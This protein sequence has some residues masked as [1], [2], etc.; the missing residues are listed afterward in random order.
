MAVLLVLS[1][2][3]CF[4]IL[5]V[6]FFN[7]FSKAPQVASSG[8]VPCTLSATPVTIEKITADVLNG[9]GTS[10]LAK[11]VADQLAER[12]VTIRNIGN[13]SSGSYEG[14]IKITAG[15]TGIN[16]AYT[17]SRAF[18]DS[19]IIFDARTGSE[20]T[21]IVGKSYTGLIGASQFAEQATQPLTNRDNCK[22]VSTD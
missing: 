20:V 3:V 16:S 1:V 10:G 6:P 18:K 4:G 19:E 5:P 22:T 12:G 11:E 2:L 7:S 13:I 15:A 14:D 21:V 9:A 17:L 8:D